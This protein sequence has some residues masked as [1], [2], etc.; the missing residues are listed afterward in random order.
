MGPAGALSRK[1]EV[2][3]SDDNQRVTLLKEENQHHHIQQLDTALAN[4]IDF[5]SSSNLIVT[6]ALT[7]MNNETGESWLLW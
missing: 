5:S 4:K 7:T 1:D 3:T 6:K 2:G